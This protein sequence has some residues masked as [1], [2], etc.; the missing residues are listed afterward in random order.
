MDR[1]INAF[2]R[3]QNRKDDEG[4]S[5][6]FAKRLTTSTTSPSIVDKVPGPTL[7]ASDLSP[8]ESDVYVDWWNALDPFGLG[9]AHEKD[10]NRFLMACGLDQDLLQQITTLYDGEPKYMEEQFYAII[11]LASHGQCGRKINRDLRH[12]LSLI[13]MLLMIYF[14]KNHFLFNQSPLSLLPK[15]QRINLE[16]LGGVSHLYMQKIRRI[17]SHHYRSNNN[18]KDNNNPCYFQMLSVIDIHMLAP[19]ILRLPLYHLLFNHNNR[20]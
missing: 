10:I 18:I 8:T 6:Q 4:R 5:H 16:I 13:K 2:S 19:R 17:S 7:S 9:I 20:P 15:Q 3:S 14:A 1:F 12:W 11:R